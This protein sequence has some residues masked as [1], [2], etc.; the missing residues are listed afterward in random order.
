[1]SNLQMIEML[2]KLVEQQASVIHH[3]AMELERARCLTEAERQM[4]EAAKRD[5]SAILG[6]DEVPDFL[7][8]Q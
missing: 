6:S 8:E 3:L 7:E 5:Y 1:M 2:C 4:M